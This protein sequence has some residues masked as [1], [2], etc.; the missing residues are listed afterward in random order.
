MTLLFMPD[1]SGFTQ[2]V[3]DVEIKH[4]KHIISELIELIDKENGKKFKLAEIE[5]DALFYYQEEEN[6]SSN[7]ILETIKRM[8]DSFHAHLNLYRFKRICNCGA[9]TS[10]AI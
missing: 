1:I 3:K 5:G 4:S 10:A 8:H 7:N 6:L 9:C 2:F